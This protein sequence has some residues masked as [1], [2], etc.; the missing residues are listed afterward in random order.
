MPIDSK[1]TMV[2]KFQDIYKQIVAGGAIAEVQE[3]SC[4]VSL[5]P[6]CGTGELTSLYN[7]ILDGRKTAKISELL[8]KMD[9]NFV[10]ANGVYFQFQWEHLEI[11]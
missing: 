10:Y 7:Q 3:F 9:S 2:I 4:D 11:R 5:N 6:N 8:S 1:F